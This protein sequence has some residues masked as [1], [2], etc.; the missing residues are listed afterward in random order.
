M[1]APSHLAVPALVASLTLLVGC[2]GGGGSDTASSAGA[3]TTGSSAPGSTA[4]APEE[5]AQESEFP[6]DTEPDSSEPSQDAR[7]TVGDVRLA[8]QDGF[9]RLVF[10]L[11]GTGTPGW[12]VRY[13]DQPTADGS[14]APVAVEGEAYLQVSITGAGYP[15]ETGVEEYAASGPLTAPGAGSITE[16]VFDGTYEGVTSAFVGTQDQ[17]PFRVYLLEN[18]TRVVVEV[19]HAG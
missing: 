4:P 7:L 19:A 1:R 2:A 13:V 14:G 11:G 15:F 18:P 12:D 17:R 10:E 6:A 16:A 5:P 8:A 9:D 3:A